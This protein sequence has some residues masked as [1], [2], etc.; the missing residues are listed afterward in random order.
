MLI[1]VG[2]DRVQ[3]GQRFYYAGRSYVLATEE[4]GR[5]HPASGLGLVLAYHTPERG[6]RIPASFGHTVDVFVDKN[7]G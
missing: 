7:R 2:I 5:K 1:S 6:D 4:E 3:Q